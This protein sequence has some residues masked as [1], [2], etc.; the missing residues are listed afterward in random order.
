MGFTN[1]I[2]QFFKDTDRSVSFKFIPDANEGGFF[3][4]DKKQFE[5]ILSGTASEW[6]THQYV[7]LKMLEEQGEAESIPNGFIVSAEVL[8]R[9]GENLRESLELPERWQGQ[10]TADIKGTTGRSSFAVE[11]AVTGQSGRDTYSYNVEGAVL[12]FGD[13][14]SYLMSQPQWLVFT[15][16]Q[17]HNESKKQE[18]DNL[19]YLH[20]L[21]LAQQNGA[22]IKLS[23]FD[24]LKIHSPEKISVEAG[25]DASGN[26]ILTPHMGQEASHDDIQRVLGQ[27][28]AP[29]ANT[30]KIGKEIILFTEEK[31]KAVKEVLNNRV[32]PKTKVKEFLENP[33]AFIDASLVD[34]DLGFSLRVRG[35][36]AFKHAYFGETDDSG[37]D[38]FGK[39]FTAEQ[40]NP[41]SKVVAD[42]KDTETLI[43]LEKIISDAKQIGASE[44]TFEGK[45]YDIN[46]SEVVSNTID[47]IKSNISQNGSPDELPEEL[48]DKTAGKVD[49]ESDETIV[50][51]IDLNDEDLSESSPLIESKIH[52]VSRSGELDWS[53]HIRTPFKHQDVGVRWILG[54]LDQSYQDEKINGALLADDMG[55][56]KTFMALSAVEH[57]YREVVQSQETQ[58]P[59]L[60]VAPLSLLENW[61]DEVAKTFDKSPFHDIVIL[62]S[63]GELKRFKNGGVEIKA[64][65]V[66]DGEFEPRYSLN[67]GKGS[68]DRLDMPGRLVITT[69]QT[70][71]DYQFS[72]CL[73]DWGV[74]IFDEAQNTKN[75]NALQTRAAKGLKSQFKLVATGTPVENSLADFWCLMDTA[76][77]G[78]LGAYQ[79][80]RSNY[81]TPIIQAA[82]DEVEEI[83]G[84]VGRELRIKVGALMLRRIKEDNLEG[85]PEKRM[86]V[87]VQDEQWKYLPELG[88]TM[89]GYQL[90][91]YDGV[92]EQL[93][94]SEENHVLGTLQRLRNGSLHPRL[95]DGGRLD[96]PKSKK[97][98]EN[99]FNESDKFKS[100]LELLDSIKLRQEKCIIFAVNK[101]LQ[102]FL[103][104]ALGLKYQLG[105]LSVI[106]G[107]AKAVAKNKATPTRKSMISD[108]EAKD[109]F[110]IIIMSPV[111]AGVG[112][113][114]VG[115][116]N[117]V[118]FERHWNPAKEAQA[119]DRVF[120]IGQTKDVNIYIPMALHPN[121]ESFDVNLHRLLSKKTQLKDAVVTPEDVLP[122]PSG[123]GKSSLLAS[124]KIITLKE[125][126]KL[127]WQQFEALTVEVIAKEYNAES[128]WLTANGADKGADGIIDSG[129][130]LILIQAK[131]TKG[132]YDGYAAIQEVAGAKTPYEKVMNKKVN[133][134]LFMTN[135]KVLS[136]R[137]REMA[138]LSNVEVIHGEE[139][140]KL[141]SKHKIDFKQVLQRL[142]KR[143]MTL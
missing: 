49:L 82:G 51:D 36:T 131:H 48:K 10:I 25:L 57:H 22:S 62:Q 63:D 14:T 23:H 108:F 53:N 113:T 102:T 85:L 42:V 143:R 130:Q 132:S 52:E 84:R 135:A 112:L 87:G 88:K 66:D 125:I 122:M 75:P 70:L 35:A 65:S 37:V 138:K 19:T 127:S 110:N 136:K 47:K 13:T 26:L 33:T 4:V 137:T 45:N 140:A 142:D 118:H 90:K 38:W 93:E 139:L 46:D 106:N 141:V 94:E 56:G 29:N 12:R 21:Q 9:L 119:T 97:E 69:Y 86:Y 99:I 104:L 32:V 103:S 71:R 120:R 34:L 92:I 61:K 117:V 77:P 96:A 73:I 114:V 74:V 100:L 124:D 1:F 80:F 8:A 55:L 107:D 15:A 39:D 133:S 98:L 5:N 81:I 105:P 24:K 2:S 44:I 116:N 60:I 28:M 58:K 115:A 18:F 50:V 3:S 76:C 16:Q 121:M 79:D 128:A 27:M 72:L 31:V 54:L 134:L 95:A 123:I 17:K 59:T 7:T 109:G 101:R 6:L 20:N 78:Y 64:N 11:L 89:A 41:I 91:V 111:A 126:E 68:A 129:N 43:Q 30:L 83:R 40:V 67:V